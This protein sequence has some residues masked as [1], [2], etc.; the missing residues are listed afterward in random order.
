MGYKRHFIPNLDYS[1]YEYFRVPRYNYSEFET[2]K[3]KILSNARRKKLISPTELEKLFSMF[4]KVSESEFKWY[5]GDI[6]EYTEEVVSYLKE[7]TNKQ[8]LFED[9]HRALGDKCYHVTKTGKA[10]PGRIL[11]EFD[12]GFQLAIMTAIQNTI[13]WDKKKSTIPIKLTTREWVKERH[14]C[15]SV[16]L[17]EFLKYRL[18]RIKVNSK[19]AK[20]YKDYPLYR[21]VV[22]SAYIAHKYFGLF[23]KKLKYTPNDYFYKSRGAIKI[24]EVNHPELLEGLKTK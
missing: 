4:Y 8:Y 15:I 6:A 12:D 3:N 22:V 24:V 13:S 21:Y 11:E 20:D 18:E 1:E 16:L 19:T 9:K 2:L 5:I 14:Q 7:N 10:I 23:E 17:T